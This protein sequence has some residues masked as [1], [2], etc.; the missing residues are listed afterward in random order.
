MLAPWVAKWFHEVN[1]DQSLLVI[2]LS[3]HGPWWEFS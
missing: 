3:H 2:W 1:L